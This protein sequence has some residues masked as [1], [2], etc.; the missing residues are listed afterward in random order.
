[1]RYSINTFIVLM[2]IGGAVATTLRSAPP[3]S[4]ISKS[5]LRPVPTKEEIAILAE[6]LGAA[7]FAD[8]EAATKKLTELGCYARSVVRRALSSKDPEVRKRAEKI[9]TTI[10]WAVF[11]G[12]KPE[13]GRYLT[14]LESGALD[15]SDKEWRKFTIEY[16]TKLLPL[17]SDMKRNPKTASYARRCLIA[18]I[19]D[20]P[21]PE[22]AKAIA[23]SNSRKEFEL[24]LASIK[25]KALPTETKENLFLILEKLGMNYEIVDLTASLWRFGRKID[26][27]KA[28]E[29]LLDDE[30]T[31][32]AIYDKALQSFNDSKPSLDNDW[33]LCFYCADAEKRRRSKLMSTFFKNLDYHPSRGG[34]IRF[35]AEKLL[36][37][38][39][40]ELA[41]EQLSGHWNSSATYLRLVA[42][43]KMDKPEKAKALK[44]LLFAEIGGDNAKTFAVATIAGKFKDPLSLELYEKMLK[45]SKFDIYVL[46]AA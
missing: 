1:M 15:A 22:M 16:G 4:R 35:T 6:N 23:A 2:V 27:S 43:K 31:A 45:S 11:P 17:L 19:A 44:K 3:P 10:R 46:N 33:K 41:L 34:V 8:R 28:A 24:M 12:A 39:L 38:S 36:K 7:R 40:P 5:P 32:T 42:V 9:W 21:P 13:I 14:R 29:R 26:I 20:V 25:M 37:L 18:L 30:K